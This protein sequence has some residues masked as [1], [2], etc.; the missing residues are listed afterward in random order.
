M[1]VHGGLFDMRGDGLRSLRQAPTTAR[2]VLRRDLFRFPWVPGVRWIG[3]G[4]LLDRLRGHD[5]IEVDGDRIENP[6]GFDVVL[7]DRSG[8]RS[9][10]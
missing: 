9:T 3:A 7:R 2:L 10:N 5:Q 1:V 8:R 6:A 4:E